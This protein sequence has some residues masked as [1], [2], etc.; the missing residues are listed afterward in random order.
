[1]Q[2][3]WLSL[4]LINPYLLKCDSEIVFKFNNKVKSNYKLQLEFFPEPF[5]GNPIK[6]KVILLNKNPGIN[7][8]NKK[9]HASNLYLEKA[10]KNLKH[11]HQEYP[12]FL[13]SV[14][15]KLTPGGIWWNKKLNRLIENTSVELVAN[16]IACIEIHGYPSQNY[17]HIDV[18]GSMLYSK[19]L[20]ELAMKRKATIVLMRG[21]SCWYEL[22]PL[23]NT[24]K[25]KIHLNNVQNPCI[26]PN[27]FCDSKYFNQ[28]IDLI[29]AP[30]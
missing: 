17:K 5:L 29:K 16:G 19:Y 23:L 18:M 15:L 2:N 14:D 22:V 20:V 13:L 24:Y 7:N 1:M 9:Y 21:F 26:T 11:A 6:S 27:N 25:Y 10:R 12:F 4:P 28:I 8:E 30:L 3:P